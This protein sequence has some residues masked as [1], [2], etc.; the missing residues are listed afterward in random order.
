MP[1]SRSRSRGF[2]LIELLVVIAITATLTAILFP[3]FA[4]AREKARQATCQSNLKQIYLAYR[5]YAD[6]YDG[7]FPAPECIG[8]SSY[9]RIDDPMSIPFLL[10]AYTKNKGIWLCPSGR[11]S[12]TQYGVNYEW[13][14]SSQI[15]AGNADLNDNGIAGLLLVYDSYNYLAPSTFNVPE[16]TGGPSISSNKYYAHSGRKGTNWLYADGH[17]KLKTWR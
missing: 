6:D 7:F 9:R 4:Q 11:E 14:R 1:Q 16:A 13:S 5:M 12:L 17:V 10:N 15:G 8:K 2:T 3:V